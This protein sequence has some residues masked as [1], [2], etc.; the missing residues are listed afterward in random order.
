M[1]EY[2]YGDW[3]KLQFVLGTDFIQTEKISDDNSQ[4]IIGDETIWYF[5][6]IENVSD[7]KFVEFINKLAK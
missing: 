1:N 5:T 6:K 3:E 7:D 4:T 2:F